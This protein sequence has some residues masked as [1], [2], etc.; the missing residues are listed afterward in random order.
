MSLSLL[1]EHN[2]AD[3]N[4]RNYIMQMVC[5][6]AIASDEQIRKAAFETLFRITDYYYDHMQAYMQELFN[7]TVNAI[8]KDT[9]DVALMVRWAMR[10]RVIFISC[11]E[12]WEV[13]CCHPLG[14]CRFALL[15]VLN[16]G[17]EH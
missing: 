17:Q 12:V 13:P 15:T 6:A 2:F 9:T 10:C 5:Q 4:E 8:R 3:A 1:A 7:I 11:L 16:R 14:R